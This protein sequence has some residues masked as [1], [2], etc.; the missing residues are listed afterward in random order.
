MGRVRDGRGVQVGVRSY[1][2]SAS[3]LLPSHTPAF[4]FRSRGRAVLPCL[5][6]FTSFPVF[7]LLIPTNRLSD[8]TS[9]LMDRDGRLSKKPMYCIGKTTA[10]HN[11]FIKMRMK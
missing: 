1:I 7:D 8:V 2:T 9:H 6:A 3:Q 10:P 4:D 5:L 11:Q